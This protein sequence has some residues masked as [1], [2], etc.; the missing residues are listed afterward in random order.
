[1]C[2]CVCSSQPVDYNTK[3]KGGRS[4][5]LHVVMGVKN[6][7]GTAYRPNAAPTTKGP[8]AA[9]SPSRPGAAGDAHASPLTPPPM[10][11]NEYSSEPASPPPTLVVDAMTV[12][13]SGSAGAAGS[14]Q[15]NL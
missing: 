14:R 15:R 3:S 8:N 11:A 5:N 10:S 6:E 4:K 1:M 12:V 9:A 7:D 2:L 13:S